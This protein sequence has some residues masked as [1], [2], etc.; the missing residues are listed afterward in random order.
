MK[1]IL[2]VDDEKNILDGVRRLLYAQRDQWDMH[3]ASSGE[4]GLRACDLHSF[5]VVVSDLRMPGM[6]GATFLS[7]VRDS[8]PNAARLILSG[9]SDAALTS[10]AVS[11]AHRVLAKPCSG[12]ALRLNIERVC[13]LQD[14]FCTPELRKVVGAIGQLPSLSNTYMAL[15]R[16]IGDPATSIA[17]V[18]AIIENDVA[19][20]AK[21]LQLVNSGFFGLAHTVTTLESAVNYLG[22]ATMKNLALMSDTFRLF[23]PSS[24]IPASFCEDMQLQSRKASLII[25]TFKMSREVR[26]VC[27]IGAALQDIGQLIL[28]CKLPAELCATFDIAQKSGCP[29][30]EA[31]EQLLGT[32]HAEIG[33]YL[34]GLWGIDSLI[35]EAVAHHHQ[36]VRIPHIGLDTSTALYVANHLARELDA[37]PDDLL[38]AKISPSDRSCLESLGIMQEYPELKAR[39]REALS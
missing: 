24:F 6:D 5:D 30:F 33:A 21:V 20:A 14:I 16:A 35:V 37:H 29:Q 15:S 1:T 32:S 26:D 36:P 17:T 18:A 4:A 34:L 3:F 11:V 25:R 2:F 39:A 28:A 13:F 23:V 38:G 9:Y 8:F 12:E 22:M 10:R 27:I 19:M 7:H 31:E